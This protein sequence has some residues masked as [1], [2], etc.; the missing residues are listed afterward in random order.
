MSVQDVD[1]LFRDP[2]REETVEQP[3]A[4]YPVAIDACLYGALVLQSIDEGTAPSVS[5][6]SW[7]DR[8]F[9]ERFAPYR[10]S[11]PELLSQALVSLVYGD[12]VSFPNIDIHPGDLL[13]RGVL[14][15][16]N[17]GTYYERESPECLNFLTSLAPLVLRHPLAAE[18][19]LTYESF[20]NAV[21]GMLGFTEY[22]SQDRV[23]TADT[24]VVSVILQEIRTVLTF[25]REQGVPAFASL[26]AHWPGARRIPSKNE[27][28]TVLELYFDTAVQTPRPRNID[29]ALTMREHP[30]IQK[31][32]DTM[33]EW[34]ARMAAGVVTKDEIVEAIRE[35]NGHLEGAKFLRDLVPRWSVFVTLPFGILN[36]IFGPLPGVTE[37]LL[38]VAGISAYGKLVWASASSAEPLKHGWYLVAQR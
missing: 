21:N 35:A 25:A 5:D 20:R 7:Y 17:T 37:G 29:E 3:D 4:Q 34:S 6:R 26:L 28:K 15:W 27:D 9:L 19:G 11:H 24:V 12:V 2:Y 22:P 18:A 38:A 33:R 31:W 10:L 32:R 8:L 1:I 14:R 16:V 36:A 23:V 13:Q 30:R